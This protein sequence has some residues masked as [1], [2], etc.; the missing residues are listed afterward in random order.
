MERAGRRD[1]L[2]VVT[3]SAREGGEFGGKGDGDGLGVRS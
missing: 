3:P 2:A 1:F